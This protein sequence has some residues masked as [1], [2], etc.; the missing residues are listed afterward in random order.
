[1]YRGIWNRFL[2]GVVRVAGI[3]QAAETIPLVAPP[4]QRRT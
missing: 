3:T 2:F 1:V 4:R